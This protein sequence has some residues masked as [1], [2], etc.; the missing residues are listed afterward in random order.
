MSMHRRER[1]AAVKPSATAVCVVI[2]STAWVGCKI[3]SG[4]VM[5]NYV[6]NRTLLQLRL[7]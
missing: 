7:P 4:V 2:S 6:H 5:L 1:A 3:T